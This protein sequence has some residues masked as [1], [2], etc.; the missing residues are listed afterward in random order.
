GFPGV[1]GASFVAG[2]VRGP[3]GFVGV[4]VVHVANG[5]PLRRRLRGV[6]LLDLETYGADEGGLGAVGVPK[7]G[8][9]KR[10]TT[11]TTDRLK[12]ELRTARVYA[13]RT[14]RKPRLGNGLAE[15]VPPRFTIR[16]LDGCSDI[17]RPG[18]SLR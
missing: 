14:K 13:R 9:R 6:H 16:P 1:F 17:Q 18:I 10:R 8:W 3:E 4:G 15:L 12:A 5:P 2:A 11:K 7:T